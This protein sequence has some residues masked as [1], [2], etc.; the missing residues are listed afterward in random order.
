[1][2]FRVLVYVISILSTN[3]TVGL[4]TMG[5][6]FFTAGKGKFKL[7]ALSFFLLAIVFGWNTIEY[8]LHSKL[9]GSTSF[10]GRL[11]PFFKCL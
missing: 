7:L 1:M 2:D 4:L 8:H 11:E 6:I 5:L 9:I 3:S 10:D